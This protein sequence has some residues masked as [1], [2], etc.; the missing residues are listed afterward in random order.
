[1]P[2]CPLA[3]TTTAETCNRHATDTGNK[4]SRLGSLRADANRVGFSGNATLPIWILLLPI[5]RLPPALTPRAM[6]ELPVVL[7]KSAPS[8]LAALLLPV[9][10]LKS[11]LTPSAVFSVTGAVV[12]KSALRPSA[13]L[14]LP[15]GVAEERIKT[16]GRVVATASH[17]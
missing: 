15:C 5:V 16:V 14:M 17:C 11:A 2:S 9:V 10:L 6:L 12:T 4:G 7:R 13:V 1:M 3:F 8:P